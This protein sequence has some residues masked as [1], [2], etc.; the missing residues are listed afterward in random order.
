MKKQ[1]TK[2]S[3]ILVAVACIIPMAAFALTPYSTDFES[4]PLPGEGVLL[5][6][7][8]LVY[9]NVFG[10]DWNWWYGYGAFPA[11]NDGAAFCAI[12]TG[13]SFSP[14]ALS[15]Y[16]DYN[17]GDHGNGAILECNVF[18]EQIVDAADVGTT[19]TYQL[20]SKLGNIGGN[21]TAGAFIKTLDPGA[22][23]AMTNFIDVDLTN[24]SGSWTTYE[25]QIAIDATLPGQ[26]LQFGF[27]S[28]AGG[29]EPS[30]IFY[31]NI[32]FNL[33]TVSN[34]DCSMGEVKMLFR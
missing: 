3:L 29:Y 31:D 30:G 24:T 20:E 2:L 14:Q 16:S 10:S 12:A 34:D 27:Y 9:A 13:E 4:N 8:W 15:V 33:S 23:W 25:L 1:L 32:E 11:P 22:G 28:Y 26:I 6:D 17:N 7:N 19:W 18:Q 5:G 21:S